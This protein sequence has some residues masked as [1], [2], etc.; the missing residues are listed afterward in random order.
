MLPVVA[1]QAVAQVGSCGVEGGLCEPVAI[2]FG[3]VAGVVE[4]GRHAF[5]GEIPLPCEGG[6]MERRQLDGGL[7]RGGYMVGLHRG[8]E[9]QPG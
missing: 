2:D 8:E 5:G 7:G 4:Q 9:L 3:H 6:G 1:G